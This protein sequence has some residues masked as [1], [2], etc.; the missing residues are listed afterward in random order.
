MGEN[1]N[2]GTG[3]HPA[4]DCYW[5]MREREIPDNIGFDHTKLALSLLTCAQ[6]ISL[7]GLFKTMSTNYDS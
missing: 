4:G 7:D 6:S 3:R 2:F 5:L 1:Y